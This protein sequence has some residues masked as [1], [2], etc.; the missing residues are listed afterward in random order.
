M[1]RL[2]SSHNYYAE[3]LLLY[4]YLFD[5]YICVVFNLNNVNSENISSITPPPASPLHH[6]P[7]PWHVQTQ[8][9]GLQD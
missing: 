2:L 3:I 9:K 8:K 7:F 4:F 1:I 5:S 6:P